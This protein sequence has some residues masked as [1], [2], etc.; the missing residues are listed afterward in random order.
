MARPLSPANGSV[1]LL[2]GA[3]NQVGDTVGPG[4]TESEPEF[5]ERCTRQAT[6]Q[7]RRVILDSYTVDATNTAR[8]ACPQRPQS[9]GEM[10]LF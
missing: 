1:E 2:L 4:K 8:K 7:D 6:A 3:A 5:P 9:C 10:R